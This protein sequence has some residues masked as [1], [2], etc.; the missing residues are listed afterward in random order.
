[1]SEGGREGGME[2]SNKRP[3][4]T[5]ERGQR[6]AH[7]SRQ[8]DLHGWVGWPV[9]HCEDIDIQLYVARDLVTRHLGR[10]AREG[11]REGKRE[12]WRKEE[13]VG[14]EGERERGRKSRKDRTG[15][16]EEGQ[17]REGEEGRI[18]K[19]ERGE[20]KSQLLTSLKLIIISLESSM[21][22]NIPSSLLVKLGPH[23]EGRETRQG[24]RL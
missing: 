18:G 8:L 3:C 10:E 12:G 19:I 16:E 14:E 15:R 4:H 21:S 6:M 5:K 11:R 13:R 1:M 24:T 23:S 9:A 2:K 22:L 7:L 17:E 20:K